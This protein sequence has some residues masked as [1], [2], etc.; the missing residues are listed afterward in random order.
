[1]VV[2]ATF[3]FDDTL[4][5]YVD[6][7]EQTP[8]AVD[9]LLNGSIKNYLDERIEFELGF[10]PGGVAR[11]I[12]WT[13]AAVQDKPPNVN[14][15]GN[16]Y[17][18][19]QKAAYFATD[20]FGG[21]IPST[22]TGAILNRWESVIDLGNKTAGLLNN[23]PAAQHVIGTFRQRFH[24]NTGYRDEEQIALEIMTARDFEDVLIE[25]WLSIVDFKGKL[26]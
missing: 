13:A 8:Q 2:D 1:M 17:Y 11:P 16:R 25:G 20:G 3:T 23:H 19:K 12:E 26:A 4:S 14:F 24:R 6:Q 18:S 22:R 15:G 9:A 10:S 7:L 5:A 21:G